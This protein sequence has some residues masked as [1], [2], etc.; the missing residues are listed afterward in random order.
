[1]GK[2][3]HRSANTRRFLQAEEKNNKI[4]LLFQ[5]FTL[6]IISFLCILKIVV[7]GFSSSVLIL[8]VLPSISSRC[9]SSRD[10]PKCGPWQL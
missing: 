6:N 8:K 2:H 10:S 9:L 3:K 4:S 1:M 7:W 5:R